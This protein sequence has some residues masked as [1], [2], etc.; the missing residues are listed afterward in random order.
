MLHA[1]LS[2]KGV[3]IPATRTAYCMLH[4]VGVLLFAVAGSGFDNTSDSM[5]P[6]PRASWA[7]ARLLELEL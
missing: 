6:F 1:L 4:V 7:F 2:S 5:C 3:Y